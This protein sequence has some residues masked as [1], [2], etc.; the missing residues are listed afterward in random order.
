M[1]DVSIQTGVLVRANPAVELEDRKF[2]QIA[3]YGDKLRLIRIVDGSSSTVETE[4]KN[5]SKD[6]YY[7]L[8]VI[9]NKENIKIYF[10]NELMIERDYPDNKI[11][12]GSIAL[13]SFGDYT[14]FDDIVV[15]TP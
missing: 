2:F 15:T 6:T 1:T 10:E 7:N 3:L 14:Y 12:S 8:K 4:V 13:S 11:T 9:V 5:Y